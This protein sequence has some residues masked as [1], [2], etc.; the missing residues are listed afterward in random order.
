MTKSDPSD[1]FILA[2]F[3]RCGRAKMLKPFRGKHRLALQ[4]LTRYRKHLVDLPCQEKMYVLNN[5]F[6]KFSEF[7]NKSHDFKTFS[8]SFSTSAIEILPNYYS[9]E[10]TV[11]TPVDN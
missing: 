4:R 10:T 6:I 8:D 7:N 2:D 9:P 5:I 1:S 11:N 3:A